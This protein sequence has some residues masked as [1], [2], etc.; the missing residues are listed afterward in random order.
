VSAELEETQD[1][2]R[3]CRLELAKAREE[4]EELAESHAKVRRAQARA[5]K[6][7]DVLAKALSD[8]LNRETRERAHGA[9]WRVGQGRISHAEWQN[10][11]IIRQSSYFRPAWYLRNN[12]DIARGGVDPALHFLRH[13]YREGRDP[14]PSFDVRQYLKDHPEVARAKQNPLLH[15]L[16]GGSRDDANGPS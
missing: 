10:V 13:G 6:E 7:A 2:L 11:K 9:W 16:L 1:E 12:L 5:Q 3:L 8:V 15:F 4:L 14:G